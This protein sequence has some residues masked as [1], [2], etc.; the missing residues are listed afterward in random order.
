M[1]LFLSG[2]SERETQRGSRVS[3]RR[4]GASDL[5][6]EKPVVIIIEKAREDSAN[7]D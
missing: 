4:V 2:T 5:K 6:R 1:V 7:L 3:K